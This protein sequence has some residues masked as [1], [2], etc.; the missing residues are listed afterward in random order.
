M[1]AGDIRD[2]VNLRAQASADLETIRTKTKNACG[3]EMYMIRNLAERQE[4]MIALL[5]KIAEKMSD[6]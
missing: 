1:D 4:R 2:M 5:S 6:G 3:L